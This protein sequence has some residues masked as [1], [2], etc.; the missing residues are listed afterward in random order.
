MSARS[1]SLQDAAASLY[2]RE[3]AAILFSPVKRGFPVT[4]RS[5]QFGD[6]SSPCLYMMEV[7]Q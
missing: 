3:A 7:V 6:Y 2:L 5:G 4:E 1:S